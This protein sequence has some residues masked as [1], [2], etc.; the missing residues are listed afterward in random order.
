[1]TTWKYP[2]VYLY[3]REMIILVLYQFDT[4]TCALPPA[5]HCWCILSQLLRQWWYWWARCNEDDVWSQPIYHRS[6]RSLAWHNNRMTAY[7]CYSVHHPLAFFVAVSRLKNL[8]HLVPL[9][10]VLRA[11]KAWVPYN[12]LW[13][14]DRCCHRMFSHA[15]GTQGYWNTVL[16]RWSIRFWRKDRLKQSQECFMW[17]LRSLANWQNSLWQRR[18]ETRRNHPDLLSKNSVTEAILTSET[19]IWKPGLSWHFF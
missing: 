7:V 12:R 11:C 1:M 9:V 8:S 17:P 19:V 4:V 10:F 13:R 16:S 15:I 6:G 14:K 18:L 2:E 3:L 5:G